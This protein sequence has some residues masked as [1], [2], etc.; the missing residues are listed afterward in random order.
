MAGDLVQSH[1]AVVFRP[2]EHRGWT[3]DLPPDSDQKMQDC[4]RSLLRNSNN[5]HH[6][7]LRQW[8]AVQANHG[9]DVKLTHGAVSPP[10]GGYE[11]APE[12]PEWLE[13][14]HRRL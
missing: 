4:H 10:P 12:A 6:R 11:I 7:N 13:S 2:I 1:Q 5:D 9:E 8:V 3:L 14:H